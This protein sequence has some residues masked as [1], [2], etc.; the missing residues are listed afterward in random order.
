[1]AA[2][3]ASRVSRDVA[4]AFWSKS[5]QASVFTRPDVLELLAPHVTYYLVTKGREPLLLW[6]AP[7]FEAGVMSS[8]SFSYYVGP[9]WSAAALSKRESSHMSM[10]LSCYEA[11][12]KYVLEDFQSLEFELPPGELD[13]RAFSWWNFDNSRM[14]SFLVEPRYSAVIDRLDHR[15]MAMIQADFR[16]LRRRELRRVG[17]S[18]RKLT[19]CAIPPASLFELHAAT[20]QRHGL[21]VPPPDKRAL[22]SLLSRQGLDC[23]H[24]LGVCDEAGRILGGALVLDGNGT[25][26]LVLNVRD[27]ETGVGAALVNEALTRA[28]ARGSKRFDFNGANSPN[29]G[30]DKHSYGA[31][32]Q[33]YFRLTYDTRMTKCESE[34]DHGKLLGRSR[35][36][37]REPGEPLAV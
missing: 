33:L 6:P 20:F 23:A 24:S 26:N 1:M 9:F 21:H 22:E 17:R 12:L 29:R 27:E 31:K 37:P 32:A 35:L 2:P 36:L 18:D 28:L 4:F 7:H 8:P 16:E 34:S 15:P 19:F 10:R 30:N 5:P 14:P 3:Q 11:V 25:S 13:V